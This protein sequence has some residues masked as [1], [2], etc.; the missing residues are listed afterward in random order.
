[1][2]MVTDGNSPGDSSIQSGSANSGASSYGANYGSTNQFATAPLAQVP[3]PWPVHRNTRSTSPGIWSSQGFGISPDETD[4]GLRRQV[5]AANARAEVVNARAVHVAVTSIAR[6]QQHNIDMQRLQS[7]SAS[8]TQMVENVAAHYQQQAEQGGQLAQHEY[9]VAQA[10]AQRADQVIGVAHQVANT[11]QSEIAQAQ[12]LINQQTQAAAA[13]QQQLTDHQS[14]TQAAMRYAEAEYDGRMAQLRN[15]EQTASETASAL[16]VSQQAF[17]RLRTQAQGCWNELQTHKQE[18]QAYQGYLQAQKHESQELQTELQ[19]ERARNIANCSLGAS[20]GDTSVLSGQVASLQNDIIRLT[21]TVDSLSRQVQEKDLEIAKW[22]SESAEKEYEHNSQMAVILAS[23]QQQNEENIAKTDRERKQMKAI[24]D[25][26]DKRHK[27]SLA[28]KDWKYSQLLDQAVGHEES[29]RKLQVRMAACTCGHCS[30]DADS[31]SAAREP[32]PTPSVKR[33]VSERESSADAFFKQFVSAPVHHYIGESK[34]PMPPNIG[35]SVVASADNLP[36]VGAQGGGA[37]KS[38]SLGSPFAAAASGSIG[39]APP[40]APLFVDP[41][42]GMIQSVIPTPSDSSGKRDLKIVLPAIPTPGKTGEFKRLLIAAVEAATQIVDGTAVPWVMEIW[43]EEPSRSTFEGMSFLNC[44]VKFRMLDRNLSGVASVA[45]AE[46]KPGIPD[47]LGRLI[48]RKG[49]EANK[50]MQSLSGRQY[51]W[52]L[53]DFLKTD[54][55]MSKNLTMVNLQ[56][57][58]W[59]GDDKIESFLHQWDYVLSNMSENQKSGLH[60]RSGIDPTIQQEFFAL[61]V[62]KSRDKVI[63]HDMCNYLNARET[64]DMVTYSFEFLRKSCESAKSRLQMK[65]MQDLEAKELAAQA[66]GAGGTGKNRL[67]PATGG[68]GGGKGGKGGKDDKDARKAKQ[69]ARDAKGPCYWH[70]AK[71]VGGANEGC[72]KGDECYFSHSVQGITKAKFEEIPKPVPK[73][74]GKGKGKQDGDKSKSRSASPKTGKGKGKS[75]ACYT[76]MNTGHC[77]KGKD[78]PYSHDSMIKSIGKQM[79]AFKKQKEDE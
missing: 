30:K 43:A 62:A 26:N 76:L 51:I 27:E 59:H 73:G 79:A 4:S 75:R 46:G 41:A 50:L 33:V 77:D 10:E 45:I 15:S 24:F 52:L 19:N 44:P 28:A 12:L 39:G 35:Q 3:A 13:A 71:E 40:V 42:S 54:T 48:T 36:M 32:F 38:T 65:K 6:E 74:G 63:E 57:I 11:A 14:Q 23:M 67:A 1:M 18:S 58:M 47:E 21:T 78:C 64:G 70:Y 9:N 7:Q 22:Q 72:R 61:Q 17:E 66:S 60:I 49:N 53:L 29:I 25:E 16:A 34:P 31:S 55:T 2:P 56:Q 20:M 8:T 5:E 68:G 69:Q 37:N